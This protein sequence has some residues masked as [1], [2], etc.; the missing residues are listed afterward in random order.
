MNTALGIHLH[1]LARQHGSWNRVARALGLDPRNLRRN[2]NRLMNPPTRRV[3]ILA[4]KHLALR[5]LLRELRSSGALTPGQIQ[6]A[7]RRVAL[8]ITP[9]R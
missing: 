7:W 2:R 9:T 3:L 1:R 4:G 6:A 8:A 5:L